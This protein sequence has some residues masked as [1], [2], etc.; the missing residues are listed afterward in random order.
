MPNKPS[1]RSADICAVTYPFISSCNSLS[2]TFPG[3]DVGLLALR[4][5]TD[6]PWR[7][8]LILS[9]V[10]TEGK[11]HRHFMLLMPCLCRLVCP[12]E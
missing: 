1:S 6:T 4:P 11:R 10:T 9:G 5:R 7:L 3:K 8:A 2:Y 12:A